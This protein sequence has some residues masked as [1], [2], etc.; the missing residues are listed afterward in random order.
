MT[1]SATTAARAKT[2][3]GLTETTVSA[4]SRTT[5]QFSFSPLTDW[6][7]AGWGGGGGGGGGGR[8]A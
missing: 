3:M 4:T 6:V 8:G 2:A 1:V 7:F 5:V